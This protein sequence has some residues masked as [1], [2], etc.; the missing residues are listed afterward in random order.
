MGKWIEDFVR[1]STKYCMLALSVTSMEF[2]YFDLPPTVVVHAAFIILKMP[3]SRFCL[4]CESS[5]DEV[6]SM[7]RFP[8]KLGQI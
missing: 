7:H 6:Q 8:T 1:K 2:T 4:V 3:S 5:Q